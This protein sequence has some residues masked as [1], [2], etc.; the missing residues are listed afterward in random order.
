M[1]AQPV[2]PEIGHTFSLRIVLA[3]RG[4]VRR[5]DNVTLPILSQLALRG[6]ERSI[7]HANGESIYRETL[8][9]RAERTGNIEL[10]PATLDAID[11]RT[12]KAEQYSS[13]ALTIIV[14]GGA[15][16][17]FATVGSAVGGFIPI[18]ERIALVLAIAFAAAL[19][20]AFWL[21]YL[22]RPPRAEKPTLAPEIVPEP[23]EPGKEA[24][25]EERLR[26]AA[27]VLRAEPTRAVVR[28]VRIAVR[29]LVGATAKETLSDVLSRLG[30]ADLDLAPLLRAL[31]RAAFTTD[32]DLQNAIRSC[33]AA[34]AE[35]VR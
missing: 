19:L 9:V 16:Q 8:T 7:G 4:Y 23:V 13:N 20:A 24:T 22:R 10:A 18:V 35:V 30:E 5:I 14:R 11:A 1:S 28:S 25:R 29:S 15:L 27:L 33:D 12:G 2:S 34:F 31:E 17:P 26:D 32:D 6:D 3:V 21:L